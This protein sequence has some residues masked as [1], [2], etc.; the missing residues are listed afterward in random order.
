MSR[1]LRLEGQTFG[2]IDVIEAT[3]RRDGSNVVYRCLCRA[4]GREC[5]MSTRSLRS[6]KSK[7][8]GC[9]HTSRLG[10]HI[11]K[12]KE[13]AGISDTNLARIKSTKAQ[14]NNTSGVRG[15][16]FT[17]GAWEAT[18]YFR[19]KRIRLYRGQSFE[20]AVLARKQGEEWRLKEAMK[21]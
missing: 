4:C 9:L 19:G 1:R 21:G 12:I 5:Y 15:V 10:D 17:D 13:N 14:R 6:A 8:C 18:L 11:G 3:D 2:Y 20:D 7:S 16:C